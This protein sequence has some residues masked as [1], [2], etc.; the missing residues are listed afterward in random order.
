MHHFRGYDACMTK[1]PRTTI[2]LSP[3]THALM[4]ELATLND[5]SMSATIGGLLE[6][7]SPV[8][9][10][11]VTVLRAANLAKDAVKG[12]LVDDLEQAQA[13]M[14]KSLGLALDDFGSMEQP[15]LDLF[16]DVKRRSPKAAKAPGD[17]S[18]MTGGRALA[19]GRRAAAEGAS[20][21][22]EDSAQATDAGRGA[23]YTVHHEHEQQ[24]LDRAGACAPSAEVAGTPIGST[25]RTKNDVNP[26]SNNNHNDG[27]LTS[28]TLQGLLPCSHIDFKVTSWPS[29][30]DSPKPSNSAPETAPKLSAS[31]SM[32][33]SAWPWMPTFGPVSP[34]SSLGQRPSNPES[35]LP[36]CHSV[37]L[38]PSQRS[39]S[40]TP[41][42]SPSSLLTPAKP[43]EP[44]WLSGSNGT[45]HADA[46]K[47]V[48]P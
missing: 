22:G 12:R 1:N 28:P 47:G 6:Q 31:P 26:T 39:G 46:S 37:S 23:G 43:I 36:D 16:E 33:W 38:C 32:P 13:R 20:L 2:T 25:G 18:D 11:V 17:A 4:K 41:T 3:A 29:V 30:Y 10:R 35:V 9:E 42:R 15:F 24:P 5:E 45:R 44:G 48:L 14:E 40:L 7:V 8:L 21:A 34:L 27:N 19:N